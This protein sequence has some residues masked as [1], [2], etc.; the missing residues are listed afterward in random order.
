MKKAP[1]AC[2]DIQ[3]AAGASEAHGRGGEFESLLWE[4]MDKKADLHP[5]ERYSREM[6]L[7]I[8]IF[9]FFA[10]FFLIFHQ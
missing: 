9:N 3:Q 6:R 5:S 8:L 1:A 4:I 7:A 2:R 10:F